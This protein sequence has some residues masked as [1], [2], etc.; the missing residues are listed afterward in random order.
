M[1]EMLTRLRGFAWNDPFDELGRSVL[2]DL[3]QRASYPLDWRDDRNIFPQMNEMQ[4]SVSRI[5]GSF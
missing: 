3:L 4:P 5:Y 1:D 2:K